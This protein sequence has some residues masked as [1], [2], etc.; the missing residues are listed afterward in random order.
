VIIGIV[1]ESF[2]PR[3]NGV[4]NSVLRSAKYLKSQGHDV[5]IIA[6]GQNQSEE[7]LDVEVVRISSITVPSIHDYDLAIT[8]RRQ[9]EKIF[10]PLL[11]IKQM[12][13]D[14]LNIMDIPLFLNFQI[15]G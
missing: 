15:Y 12:S 10:Q 1:A 7:P 6:A 4:S 14:L 9:L 8:T 13:Q 11:F 3:I 5:T 2:W